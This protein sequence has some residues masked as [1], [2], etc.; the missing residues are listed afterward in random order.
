MTKHEYRRVLSEKNQRINEL[1]E[2]NQKLREANR[3]LQAEGPA[4]ERDKLIV[5]LR[6]ELSK[7][8]FL[9][10]EKGERLSEYLRK[11]GDLEL[12]VKVKNEELRKRWERIEELGGKWEAKVEE[13]SEEMARKEL[14][15]KGQDFIINNLNNMCREQQAQLTN[16]KERITQWEAQAKRADVALRD[17]E[18]EV[19]RLEIDI[20]D[21]S[22]CGECG[23]ECEKL[24]ENNCYPPRYCDDCRHPLLT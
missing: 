3:R 5:E 2:E 23:E 21:L 11:I 1:G 9:N 16:A 18:E 19:A 6:E 22:I 4:L 8:D 10:F 17:L 24:V 7:R 13:M 15:I 12:A 20:E 14:A